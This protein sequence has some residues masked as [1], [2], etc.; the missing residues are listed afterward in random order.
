MRFPF[1][2][3]RHNRTSFI[4]IDLS[5]CE[6]CGQCVEAC[7]N[8]VLE[9]VRFLSHCHVHVYQMQNCKGCFKCVRVCKQNAILRCSLNDTRDQSH[10]A[11]GIRHK[12][13]N[14]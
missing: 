13:Y 2:F 5:A 4:L 10:G 9:L 14:G 7:T 12:C 11:M 8:G 6:A 3:P 1:P